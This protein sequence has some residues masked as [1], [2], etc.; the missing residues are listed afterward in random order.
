MTDVEQIFQAIQGL[1]VPDRR[2]LIERVARGLDDAKKDGQRSPPTE[3]DEPDLLGLLADDPE[4]AD[5]I[6][7][8]ATVERARE[9]MRDWDAGESDP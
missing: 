6:Y 3:G 7:K 1:P 9:T 8:I 5:E 4:L 2:R